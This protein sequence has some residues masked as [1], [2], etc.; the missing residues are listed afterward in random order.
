MP[1]EKQKRLLKVLPTAEQVDGTTFP[2]I[3]DGQVNPRFVSEM[4]GFPKDWTELPFLRGG[5]KA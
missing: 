3:R 5:Q 1:S 4:M 2:Y